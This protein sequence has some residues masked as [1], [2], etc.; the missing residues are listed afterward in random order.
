MFG[1]EEDSSEEEGG[2][3]SDEFCVHHLWMVPPCP[4][5]DGDRAHHVPAQADEGRARPRHQDPVQP[6][7]IME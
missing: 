2:P 7:K 6:D 4:D 3:K 5:G 1:L